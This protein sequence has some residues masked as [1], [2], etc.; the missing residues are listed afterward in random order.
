MLIT[1]SFPPQKCG[2]GDYSFNLA[3]AL[4][5]I[6]DIKVGVLTSDHQGAV[7]VSHGMEVF[8]IIK[9]WSLF[10]IPKIIS[11]IRNWS[12][13]IVH[14][15]YPTQGYGRRLLPN[16][17]PLI[18][19]LMGAKI[20]QTWHEGFGW[21]RAPQVLMKSMIPGS[22]VVVRPQYRRNLHPI[23]RWILG[24]R[25]LHF[26]RNAS[27][28]PRVSLS[29]DERT[30]LRELNL[31]GQKRLIVFFGFVYQ[32]KGVTLL[33]DI[34]NPGS[35]HIVIAGEIDQAGEYKHEIMR[36]CSVEPW[37]GK[38]TITGFLA[39]ESV[40][41]LL[42]V[43][44]AVVLP[45]RTGGGEWNTSI[46]SAILQGTFVITTSLVRSGYDI[47]HNIYYSKI[48][49]VDSMKKALDVYSGTKREYTIDIDKDDWLQIAADHHLIYKS[50]LIG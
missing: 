29:N 37:L 4:S 20:V 6:P 17:L 40:A 44:D 28:V 22:L 35:D 32:K 13:D 41:K 15:Q 1:G 2:V 26:I 19:F 42:S 18:C 25:E 8:P 5:G 11:I 47:S 27:S 36:R 45:F 43:A 31:K 49:D 12:P 39:S 34:A 10:E 21:L 16:L 33:F 23:L 30:A 24:S 14:I 9:R 48:D 46:H 3:Q 50:I 38:V 7:K